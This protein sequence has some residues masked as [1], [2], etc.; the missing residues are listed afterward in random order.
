MAKSPSTSN[1]EHTTH[2]RTS[3]DAAAR[4]RRREAD[5]DYRSCCQARPFIPLPLQA[6]QP[7]GFGCIVRWI[8]NLGEM[9][10]G[11]DARFA[12]TPSG[13]RCTDWRHHPSMAGL[14]W[15]SH[16]RPGRRTLN[17]PARWSDSLRQPL[18]LPDI[19]GI[20]L[21][22]HHSARLLFPRRTA[23]PTHCRCPASTSVTFFKLPESDTVTSI[24]R[25]DPRR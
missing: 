8:A 2:F 12:L 17:P 6:A 15:Q 21:V 20:P 13:P 25:L 5:L 14:R 22:G 16:S 3:F 11:R 4:I 1:T 23:N 10:F 24:R 7:A 19:D 18:I 9:P